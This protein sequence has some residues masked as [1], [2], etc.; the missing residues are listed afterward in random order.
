[1]KHSERL[2]SGTFRGAVRVNNH[3]ESRFHVKNVLKLSRA[4]ILMT[5]L[6]KS[7]ADVMQ[8]YSYFYFL[9]KNTT[10]LLSSR[11]SH[12]ALVKISHDAEV[13]V[14]SE[15]IMDEY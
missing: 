2:K 4:G 7:H 14:T 15:I 5:V 12:Q 11:F 10:F 9:G 6:K 13:S 3:M 1:M 8:G